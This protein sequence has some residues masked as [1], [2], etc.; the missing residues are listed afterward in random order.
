MPAFEE[1]VR[2]NE[3]YAQSF[4]AGDLPIPPARQ[5]AVVTCMD[6]RLDPE[7]FLGLDLGDA[8]VIR[9]AGG[10]VSDD[11]LRSLVISQRLLGTNEVVIIH[12]TGCGMMSFENEDIREKI[13]S[14]LGADASGTDFLPFSELEDS[15][16]DDVEAVRRSEFVPDDISVSGAVYE[17]ET[18]RIREVVSG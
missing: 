14:D 2:A 11:A 12:H 3:S 17:V 15:V 6:A 9:N 5:V 1:F 16:R 18:G 10:R 8:H 4:D 7:S 13:K